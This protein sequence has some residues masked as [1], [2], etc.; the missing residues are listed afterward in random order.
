MSHMPMRRAHLLATERE[1]RFNK[2]QFG[3]QAEQLKFDSRNPATRFSYPLEAFPLLT[4]HVL[5]VLNSS[6]WLTVCPSV[7]LSSPF[8]GPYILKSRLKRS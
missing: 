3:I 4:L 5:L 6:Y 1:T 8:T 7:C 2:T